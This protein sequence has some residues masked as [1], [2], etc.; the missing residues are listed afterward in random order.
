MS[1]DF[2]IQTVAGLEGLRSVELTKSSFEITPQSLDT[3]ILKLEKRTRINPPP[4]MLEPTW[5]SLEYRTRRISR[6]IFNRL[7]RFSVQEGFTDVQ[8]EAVRTALLRLDPE[9]WALFSEE[10]E[11]KV[12]L[13]TATQFLCYI[14]GRHSLELTSQIKSLN[15]LYD[16][17]IEL[18][19]RL[20]QSTGGGP[21]PPP[22][23]PGMLSVPQRRP[24]KACGCCACGCHNN[25]SVKKR[26]CSK[27]STIL[28]WGWLKKL[29]GKKDTV[30]SGDTTD[31]DEDTLAD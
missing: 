13:S 4:P 26:R 2:F 3:R 19:L 17:A 11:K 28:R 20:E 7:Q 10:N 25:T 29:F 31:T 16:F 21:P 9:L 30:D 15:H 23:H 27:I 6:L 1:K 24:K 14:A 5:E 8:P 18:C 12:D 22:R